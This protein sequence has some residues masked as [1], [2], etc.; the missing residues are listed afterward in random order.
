MTS[1]NARSGTAPATEPSRPS[2]RYGGDG[3]H[4]AEQRAGAAAREPVGRAEQDRAERTARVS[5]AG[6]ARD[7]EGHAEQ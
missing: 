6:D 1:R 5:A 7:R 3:Q 2:R 4:S